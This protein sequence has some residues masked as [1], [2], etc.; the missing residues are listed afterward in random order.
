[1][2]WS[3]V[4]SG[5]RSTRVCAPVDSFSFSWIGRRRGTAVRRQRWHSVCFKELSKES[6]CPRSNLLWRPAARRPTHHKSLPGQ[7][8]PIVP[9]P[10]SPGLSAHKRLDRGHSC[11][12][13]D[14]AAATRGH[15]SKT[16]VMSIESAAWTQKTRQPEI[17]QPEIHWEAPTLSY[18]ETLYAQYLTDPDS[19]DAEWRGYFRESRANGDG[20]EVAEARRAIEGPGFAAA[21]IFNPPGGEAAPAVPIR[22]DDLPRLSETELGRRLTFL[23]GV[24]LFS[25]ISS[26]DLEIVAPACRRR[27]DQR[28]PAPL[29]RGRS[30]QF[31][32]PADRRLSGDPPAR[33][34]G[35]HAPSRRPGG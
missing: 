1:M 28:R 5:L 17:Q 19:V 10:G 25:S 15:M 24:E 23:R 8:L 29:P 26:T 16:S 9:P 30:R 21:S 18:V 32:L 27:R 31:P 4:N 20:L 22:I 35:R 7:A 33:R 13:A 2:A 3:P 6:E 14:L 11:V 12:P 34:R